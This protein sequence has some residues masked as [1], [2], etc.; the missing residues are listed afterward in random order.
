MGVRMSKEELQF[1]RRAAVWGFPPATQ[2]RL[3][4][5]LSRKPNLT[6]GEICELDALIALNDELSALKGAAL[7]LLRKRGEPVG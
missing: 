6:Q 3:D 5:L 2:A 7:L 1:V 4:D